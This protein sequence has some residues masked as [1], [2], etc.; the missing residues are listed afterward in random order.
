MTVYEVRLVSEL[1]KNEESDLVQNCIGCA[2]SIE[3]GDCPS[4]GSAHI[5]QDVP[6]NSEIQSSTYKSDFGI[7][8]G[9]ILN[10]SGKRLRGLTPC[11]LALIS[12]FQ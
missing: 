9:N 1:R 6:S 10:L 3:M 4:G 7:R 2:H 12:E 11:F 8:A 5:F